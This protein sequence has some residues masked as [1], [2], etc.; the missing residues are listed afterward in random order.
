MMSKSIFVCI[1]VLKE[2]IEFDPFPRKPKKKMGRKLFTQQYDDAEE[3]T[4]YE[5]QTPK[6]VKKKPAEEPSL[7]IEIPRF[8]HKLF[9]SKRFGSPSL[10]KTPTSK[11]DIRVD[12]FK[13]PNITK[14]LAERK[15][16][17][18]KLSSKK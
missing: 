10:N 12:E 16:P 14:I 2:V 1:K 13:T 18:G 4:E 15:T 11:T 9:D 3:D 6:S 7:D 17:F 8:T 5:P